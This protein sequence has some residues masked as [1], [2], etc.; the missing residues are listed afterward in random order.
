MSFNI[1]K[2]VNKVIDSYMETFETSMPGVITA[3]NVDGTVDVRPSIRNCLKNMQMEPDDPKTGDIMVLKGVPV[4]WP[5]T[6]QAI[7][8][9]TLSAGD[10]VLLISS[11][12]DTRKWVDNGWASGTVAPVSFSGNGLNDMMAI[13]VRRIE[14]KSKPK[15]SITIDRNGGILVESE[16][17]TIKA[18]SCE[19]SGDLR[20]TGRITA[21]NDIESKGTVKGT[22]DVK[23]S[24]VSLGSHIHSVPGVT[25][26]PGA[27]TTMVPT[28]SP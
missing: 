23:T 8:Q 12:R 27:T 5:G 25:P 24:T 11:S 4:L 16:S 1:V 9:F 15:T 26:G 7:V 3:V 14:H 19:I 20:V 17:A 2:V 6:D 22:V 28:P 13:P 18:K 21:D 10:P